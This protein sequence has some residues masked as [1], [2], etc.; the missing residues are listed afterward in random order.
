MDHI[1]D[2]G[3]VTNVGDAAD[4]AGMRR[5]T[6]MGGLMLA[7]LLVR[8]APAAADITA[9]LGFTPTMDT[10]PARGFAAGINLLIVGFE[11][12][13]SRMTEHPIEGAPGLTTGMFNVL[14][15][16][17]TSGIQLYLTAGGGLYRESLLD[18]RET[19]FATNVGG[20][21]KISLAGPIRLR[22]DYRVFSLRGSPFVRTPHRIYTGLSLSF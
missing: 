2:C 14:V 3:R 13:Y 4:K 10:R 11:F 22:V 9:F 16:T 8:P 1:C 15:L 20:G 19:H 21:A 18:E 6:L 5:V 17:P 7:C 12:E